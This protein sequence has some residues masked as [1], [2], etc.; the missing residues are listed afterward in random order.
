MKKFTLLAVAAIAL[1]V[2]CDKN[3]EGT[4]PAPDKPGT[5][6]YI[7]I[8][9]SNGSQNVTK[10][11]T[12]EDGSEEESKVGSLTALLFNNNICIDAVK[13]TGGTIGNST[14]PATASD[15]MLVD[16]RSTHAMVVANPE[17]TPWNN[18][19][20]DFTASDM[21]TEKTKVVGKSWSTINQLLNL[22]AANVA[23]D[24][25]FTMANAGSYTE[26]A[27]VPVTVVTADNGKTDEQAK[28]EAKQ[29]SA[30]IN[31]DRLSSKVTFDV[32][33]NLTVAP[34]GAVFTFGNW[35]LNVTNKS[36]Y[37]YSDLV[38]LKSD[39]NASGDYRRD[40]N[41]DLKKF[42][43]IEKAAENRTQ[44]EK[45]AL[46][47]ALRS[48]FDFLLNAGDGQASTSPVTRAQGTSA[49]CL[50]NTMDAPAQ[51][52]GVTTSVVIK[53]Q[54]TPK[55]IADAGATDYFLWNYQYYTLAQIKAAYKSAAV[56][57]HTSGIAKDFPIFLRAA[58]VAGVDAA[59]TDDLMDTFVEGL[60]AASFNAESGIIGRYMA[61]RYFH[62]SVCY[63]EVLIRHDQGITNKMA[64]GRYGVVRN[65]WYTINLRSVSGPGTPW[66]PDPSDPDPTDPTNPTDPTDPTGPTD[67]GTNDDSDNSYLAVTI[68]VRPWTA[69][70]YEVDI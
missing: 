9:M 3:T 39:P 2:S 12:T 8:R 59:I 62:N 18:L 35:E 61:V 32:N 37:L 22:A 20:L 44:A 27:L 26:G 24:E 23:T 34:A 64:L 14:T 28:T 70:S 69:W 4:V 42:P 49:Y 45:A 40:G 66:I 5:T 53:A 41:Y 57:S 60:T 58:K 47:T 63:Y 7:S 50:E 55:E 48:E 31:I 38:S 65:N 11:P 68:T 15:A 19:K 21:A 67:P 16:A 51:K 54:Y 13:I 1:Q 56:T 25:H 43:G 36:S 6:G 10:A 46:S 52:K 30:A 29:K 33:S 17:N